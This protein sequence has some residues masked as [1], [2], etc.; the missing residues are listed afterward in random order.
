MDGGIEEAGAMAGQADR[1]ADAT[2]DLVAR[3]RAHLADVTWSGPAA[4]RHSSEVDE[5]VRRL[6]HALG[7]LREAA[8]ELQQA[9]EQAIGNP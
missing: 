7:Q 5:S 1:A 2:E 3:I 4:R 9:A 6:E 8:A